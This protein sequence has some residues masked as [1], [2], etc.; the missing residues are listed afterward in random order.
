MCAL[1]GTAAAQGLVFEEG[2]LAATLAKAKEQDKLVF[3]DV[4]TS[5]CGPCKM[6]SAEVFPQKE[7]G[8]FFNANFLN[9]KAD[10][11]KSEDGRHIARTYNVTAY[12][13]FLFVNGDGEL[14]YRFL[15]AKSVP[16]LIE[17]GKKAVAAQQV[18]PE[19]KKYEAQ[20]NNGDR[21]PTFLDSY[22]RVM[23]ASGLDASQVLIDYLSQADESE[24]L[25]ADNL[26]HIAVITRYDSALAERLMSGLER[27][28]AAPEKDEKA[29]SKV[30]SSIAKYFSGTARNIAMSDDESLF[31]EYLSMKERFMALGNRNSVS[32]AMMGGGTFY[33]PT[34]MLQ[35][36]YYNNKGDGERFTAIFDRYMTDVRESFAQADA[37]MQ[38]VVDRNNSLIEE[39]TAKGDEKEVKTLRSS[40]GLIKT[41]LGMDNIYI[42]TTLL[43]YID[44]YD[45]YY[46]GAKDEAYRARL[47][48]WYT[49]LPGISP[50]VKS[51]SYAADK[52]VELGHAESAIAVLELGLEKGRDASEVT[53][54]D[55]AAAEEK[56]ATLKAAR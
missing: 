36:D 33:L 17:E 15:G 31:D 56:L 4:Y 39:A 35:L 46:S 53:P 28:N 52:L 32:I 50:S 55:I 40:V 45:K 9:F 44:S 54:D 14:V 47:A 49:Y 22:A 8:D 25:S 27:A 51:A 43:E 10:A 16:E 29:L 20:Y 42:S 2:T 37:A 11:E 30:N 26:K 48:E 5:W 38:S 34:E 19:L 13:T 18:Y 21:T 41:L 12:P 23:A 6:M 7:A 1:C 3:V 24:L